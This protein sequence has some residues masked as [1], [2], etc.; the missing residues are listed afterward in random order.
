LACVRD[1]FEGFVDFVFQTSHLGLGVCHLLC[2]LSRGLGFGAFG[3][4]FG[5]LEGV[6]GF[7]EL[8]GAL[9]DGGDGD[10]LSGLR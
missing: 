4:G 3:L 1:L 10:L 5:G 2:C 7:G 8:F 9:L 6:H